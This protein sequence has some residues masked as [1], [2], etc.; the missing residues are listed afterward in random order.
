[1]ANSPPTLAS[2]DA[3]ILANVVRWL[4][5]PQSIS[6][7]DRVARLFH[8][9]TPCSPVEEGLR[10][11]AE[12]AGRSVVAALPAQEAPRSQWLMWLER[13]AM[14][15]ASC[16]LAGGAY[17]SAFVEANGTLLTCGRDDGGRGVLGQGD[18][19]LVS[20]VPHAITG[21]V[22]RAVAATHAHTLLLTEDGG[23]HSFGIGK[24]GRLGHGD[25]ADQHWPR[26]IDAQRGPA[27]GH[28]AAIA[29][30]F[31]HSLTVGETGEVFS[32]GWG[33]R[34]RLGQG[35]EASQSRPRR[36]DALR[37]V[38]VSSLAAG[39][40]HS[41]ALSETGEVYSFGG[42]SAG[43]LGHGDSSSTQLTPRRVEA[44]RL[45]R[46]SAVAAGWNHSLALSEA[47]E[48]YSFGKGSHGRLG[49]NDEADQ[50]T[51][52]L[53]EALRGARVSAVAAGWGHSLVLRKGEVHSF[54]CGSNSATG[55][56]D[57]AD[58]RVPR[59]IQA[60][61]GVR[62]VAVAAG[63]YHSLLR[64]EDGSTYSF[65]GGWFCQLGHGNQASQRRPRLIKAL[66]DRQDALELLGR[67]DRGTGDSIC[68]S[69][70]TS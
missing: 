36:I 57:E 21:L 66:R 11:R 38:R 7:L 47:G 64:C 40:G 20:A 43:E 10:L 42:E 49:H 1:M 63:A 4:D 33:L 37:G 70:I 58:R 39:F 35:D 27:R 51:P 59:L 6:R 5:S 60:L 29:V 12:A 8:L 55:H 69:C 15:S 68:G 30:G 54:G 53:I 13:Q 17:H 41:L 19:R 56:G 46:V 62:V 3:D 24:D 61:R 26:R 67:G 14:A 65:G 52:R 32:F 23:I 9:G 16:R 18:G 34:G 25:E 48:V 50:H 2:L 22:V 45:V 31:A 28:I 44:L